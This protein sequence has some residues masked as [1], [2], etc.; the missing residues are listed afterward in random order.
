MNW[1][2]IGL[3]AAGLVLATGALTVAND[4]AHRSVGVPAAAAPPATVKAPARGTRAAAIRRPPA[5]SVFVVGD[6]LT[7]GSRR[8]LPPALRA[9]GWT[10]G[11]VDARVGRPVA[12]G[13]AILRARGSRLP[14]DVV[15]ALGTNDLR[16][17]QPEVMQWLRSARAAVGQRRLI[18]VNLCLDDSSAPRLS[19]FRRINAALARLA[20]QFGI[21]V[22]DWCGYATA[23]GVAPGPDGIHYGRAGYRLRA[24]FYA[25]AVRSG[26]PA[27]VT[28][29]ATR[30]GR[31]TAES[32]RRDAA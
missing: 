7:V 11:G 13:L 28:G 10:L 1:R 26:L 4:P 25:D 30:P 15:V 9:A 5:A 17:R 8:W 22:A 23:H 20:P 21:E 27:A 14:D 2:S 12:E 24:Q 16:A 18:W 19:G 32:P 3:I 29:T 6:S 31:R